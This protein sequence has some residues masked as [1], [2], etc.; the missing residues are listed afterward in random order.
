LDDET[1]TGEETI[2]SCDVIFLPASKEK[3]PSIHTRKLHSPS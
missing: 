2:L 3:S 1:T